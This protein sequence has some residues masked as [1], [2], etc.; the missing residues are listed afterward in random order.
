MNSFLDCINS[1]PSYVITIEDTE[2]FFSCSENQ[3]LL[4]GMTSLGKRGI[5]SGC[6]G[7]GCG[8]CKVQITNGEVETLAMSRSHV[9]KQEERSGVVLACRTLPRSSVSLKVIGKLS[10]NILNRSASSKKYGFL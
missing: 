10:N 6:H 9:S 8:V 1:V 2:E 4:Q 7:G 3:H 5:P